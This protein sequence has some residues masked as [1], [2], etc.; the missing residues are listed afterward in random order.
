[1]KDTDCISFLQWALPRLWLRWRGFRR[2]RNQVCKRIDR[3][4]HTLGLGGPAAYRAYLDEHPEEWKVLDGLCTVSISR[5][6]RDRAVFDYLG[7]PVLPALARSATT[8]TE[9]TVRCWSAGCASGEEAYTL[10]LIWRQRISVQFPLVTFTIM[11]TDIDGYLLDRARVACY[12]RSSL[13][14]LPQAWSNEAFI[15][16]GGEYCLRDAWKACVEFRQQDI[17]HDQPPGPF[18]LVLCRNLAFTYFDEATQLRTAEQLAERVPA[19]GYL[20]VGRHETLPSGAPFVS[21]A[22][23][24]GVYRRA[25]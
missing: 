13:K 17:R 2:V 1:V 21:C 5:F 20:V 11:A 23:G 24:L 12:A 7:D 22:P 16:R 19:T 3:R 6:Y 10:S 14:E 25:P 9:R 18:N 8:R 15:R 4:I